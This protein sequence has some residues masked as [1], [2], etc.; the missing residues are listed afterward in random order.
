MSK[1]IRDVILVLLF[2]LAGEGLIAWGTVDMV[3]NYNYEVARIADGTLTAA[4]PSL[5]GG[6]IF[7]MVAGF[8]LAAT[9]ASA[10]LTISRR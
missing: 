8:C 7:Y 6:V 5:L 9:S 4:I 10:L 1:K 3:N 2:T